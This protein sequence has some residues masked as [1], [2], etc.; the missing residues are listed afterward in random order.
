V[1]NS[2]T[3]CIVKKANRK[4][5]SRCCTVIKKKKTKTRGQNRKATVRQ[6]SNPAPVINI[7]PYPDT[8][9]QVPQDPA[10][11]INVPAPIV[12]VGSPNVTV[13]EPVVQVIMQPDPTATGPLQSALS[14]YLS[15]EGG[16]T[17]FAQSGS[18]QSIFNR[19]GV[20]RELRP[21]GLVV[22]EPVG[23]VPGEF[24]YFAVQQIVGFHYPRYQG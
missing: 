21:D 2:H 14:A 1:A 7:P 11:I 4:K 16:V 17:L 5:G 6:A 13:P 15:D 3:T 12:Q 18:M 8:I 10:P 24:L 9:V 20:L 23:A 19:S 22:L